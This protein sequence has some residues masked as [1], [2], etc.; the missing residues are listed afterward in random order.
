MSARRRSSVAS[1]SEE[2]RSRRRVARIALV[3]A[4]AAILFSPVAYLTLPLYDVDSLRDRNPE[5]TALMRLR[6]EEALDEGHPFRQERHWVPLDRISVH[7]RNA[8][9]VN[10][11]ATFYEHSGFDAHEIRESIRKNWKE[12]RFARGASTISQQLVKN[13]YL[14]TEKSLRRKTV[15]AFTTW[16]LE[17]ALEKDRI[18]EIYLNVIE[19]G[20]GVFGAE[21]AARRYFDVSA[22]GLNPRQAALLASAIPSPRRLD[23]ARPGPYLRKQA[24]ITLERMRAR[25]MINEE[26]YARW[27]G[28]ND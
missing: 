24:T 6:A 8:V 7:L 5:T 28:A 9:I 27:A 17:R 15:E 19:W 21:A 12:R 11:D 16:R 13:L 20:D 2:R 14:G 3:F 26:T 22:A 18:L 4:L 23:P 10:E 1:R 25:G